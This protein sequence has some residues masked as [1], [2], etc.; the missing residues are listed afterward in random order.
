MVVTAPFEPKHVTE[1]VWKPLP[2]VVEHAP[3]WA[4]TY[5]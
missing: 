4:G 2:H 3:H 1:R 5:W